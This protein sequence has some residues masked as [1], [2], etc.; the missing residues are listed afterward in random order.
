MARTRRPD[1]GCR[2]AH[3][4]ASG[5]ASAGR[6]SPAAARP[7]RHGSTVSCVSRRRR[8]A[9][10][11]PAPPSTF[12]FSSLSKSTLQL[13]GDLGKQ[14]ARAPGC[15]P[16]R[17]MPDRD[18]ALAHRP[19]LARF[20]AVLIEVHR[21]H[22]RHRTQVFRAR[23]GCGIRP[24]T[25]RGRGELFVGG[26]DRGGARSARQ[27]RP[28]DGDHPVDTDLAGR[29]RVAHR[30]QRRREHL[31]RRERHRAARPLGAAFTRSPAR[32]F[33]TRVTRCTSSLVDPHP[34]RVVIRS[35]F[36]RPSDRSQTC[37]VVSTSSASPARTIRA[38]AAITSSTSVSDRPRAPAANTSPTTSR[39]SSPTLSSAAA[40]LFIPP[41]WRGPPTSD[42][43]EKTQIRG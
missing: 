17:H 22:R 18:S 10:P 34:N 43:P 27:Q 21:P 3:R 24:L 11:A 4:A 19:I 39:R 29:E 1:S 6:P 12:G 23:R 14:V 30:R 25:A 38:A 13:P 36:S 33:D 28:G 26:E 9:R 2:R 41:F 31:A 40:M 15:S 42:R 8:P 35:A 37:P 16:S 32:S 5:P 20:G 7:G